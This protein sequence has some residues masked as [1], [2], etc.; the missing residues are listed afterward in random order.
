MRR[1]WLGNSFCVERVRPISIL[2]PCRSI[3]ICGLPL[4]ACDRQNEGCRLRATLYVPM[5]C[6]IEMR[7]YTVILACFCLASSLEL[8]RA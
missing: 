8:H 4:V 3:T 6:T 7:R 5:L 2:H 1:A